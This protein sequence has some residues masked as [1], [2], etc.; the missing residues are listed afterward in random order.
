MGNKSTQKQFLVRIIGITGYFATFSGGAVTS[1]PRKV[2]DGGSLIPDV[3]GS[4]AQVENIVVGRHYDHARDGALVVA[5][6]KQVGKGVYTVS[7]TPTNADLVPIGQ[8][9]TYVNC[10]L[11]RVTHSDYA[12]D[13]GDP[14]TFELEFAPSTVV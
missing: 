11:V 7:V 8:P 10:R 5:L 1:E 2:Y 4:P 3:L 13:S 14:A 12:S 6:R 9:D